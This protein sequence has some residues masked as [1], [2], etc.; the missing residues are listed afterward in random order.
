MLQLYM[1][2]VNQKET[3]SFL[4]FREMLSTTTEWIAMEFGTDIHGA[5][6]M[7]P[8]NFGDSLTFY[9]AHPADQNFPA[10]PVKYLKSH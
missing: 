10:Y 4:F 6:K 3:S 8:A 7:N 2:F 9:V 5:K 1:N